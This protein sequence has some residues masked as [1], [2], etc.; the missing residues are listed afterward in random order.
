MRRCDLEAQI[1]DLEG[2]TVR[3]SGCDVVGV[4]VHRSAF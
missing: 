2:D 3:F 1:C 4:E